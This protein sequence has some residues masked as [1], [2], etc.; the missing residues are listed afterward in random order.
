MGLGA[1]SKPSCP[2]HTFSRWFLIC[3]DLEAEVLMQL[4]PR[5]GAESD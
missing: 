4:P 3:V 1:V 5:L 2:W